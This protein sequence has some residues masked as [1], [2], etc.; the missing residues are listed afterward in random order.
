MTISFFVHLQD[1]D[2]PDSPS[3]IKF[4]S[5]DPINVDNAGPIKFVRTFKDNKTWDMKCNQ[6]KLDQTDDGR[7]VYTGDSAKRIRM[8]PSLP[9]LYVPKDIY[10][11]FSGYMNKKYGAK[12]CV[13]DMNICRF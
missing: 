6:L 9:Y 2:H 7:L 12:T 8:D 10:G 11:E 4:G 3:S 13:T 1:S 5:W